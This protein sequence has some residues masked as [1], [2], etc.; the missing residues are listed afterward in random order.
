MSLKFK[1]KQ[2]IYFFTKF[3]DINFDEVGFEDVDIWIFNVDIKKSIVSEN[4]N[5][6]INQP[7]TVKNN[8]LRLL[9]KNTNRNLFKFIQK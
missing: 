7:I 1:F 4:N 9:I 2:Y 6:F 5:F 8:G 3:E